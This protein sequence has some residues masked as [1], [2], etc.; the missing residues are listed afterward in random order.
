MGMIRQKNFLV[1]L[2]MPAVLLALTA[3]DPTGGSTTPAPTIS[4]T[5]TPSVAPSASPTPTSPPLVLAGECSDLVNAASLAELVGSGFSIPDAASIT[6]YVDKIRGEG[7]PL[8]L[9]VDGGGLLCP[10][11]NGTRVS[12]VFG[13][14]P[15]TP[16]ESAVQK[17]RLLAEGLTQSAHLGGE[18]YSDTSGNDNVVFEYLVVGGYWFSAVDVTR[19][20]EVV[21]N[22][23]API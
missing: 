14:S 11:T 12:E 16:A 7:S 18:L 8:A 21:A 4:A 10:V 9:F 6:A 17:A 20:D 15:I 5:S 2:A 19:L 23:G 3:C 1:M 22:S 13:F